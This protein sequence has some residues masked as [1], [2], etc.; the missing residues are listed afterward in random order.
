ML[1]A[2]DNVELIDGHQLL[3]EVQITERNRHYRATIE[4]AQLILRGRTVEVAAG[5]VRACGLLF[6]MSQIFEDFVAHYMVDGARD[7][8]RFRQGSKG[9]RI[10]LDEDQR[11][12]LKPDLTFWRRKECVALGDVK[13]KD[14][15]ERG[16]SNSDVY[17]LVSYALALGLDQATLVHPGTAETPTIKIA[18][19]TDLVLVEH[20]DVSQGRRHR[21]TASR[22]S[23]RRSSMARV[24]RRRRCLKHARGSARC[25]C[26]RSRS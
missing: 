6:D 23:D 7:G 11:V 13:Y 16:V 26:G 18:A 17:Q 5:G 25:D 4:L 9:R 22:R 24:R 19:G 2:F 3:S 21:S 15:D 12:R 10:F 20:V 14:I 8:L 1:P